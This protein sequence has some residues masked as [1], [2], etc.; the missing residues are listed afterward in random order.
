MTIDPVLF[1]LLISALASLSIL[2]VFLSASFVIYIRKLHRYQKENDTLKQQIQ[3]K[4]IM[5]VANAREKAI[6]IIEEASIE[7][8]RILSRV[9]SFDNAA[10]QMLMKEI[11][12]IAEKQKE[13]LLTSTEELYEGY[14]TLIKENMLNSINIFKNISKN[15]EQTAILEVQDF[16]E[17]MEK[18]TMQSQKIVQEKIRAEYKE[19][20]KELDEYKM[21]KLKKI[22][23]TIY[24]LLQTVSRDLLAKVINLEDHKRLILLSLDQL[25]DDLNKLTR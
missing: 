11:Q 25:K 15:V 13:S 22:D 12:Y 5:L 2:V 9:E 8:Q 4:S 3:E 21:Q 23:E 19:L 7:A 18:E 17:T 24:Q 6:R 20:E 16:K 14:Q 10:K 1:I